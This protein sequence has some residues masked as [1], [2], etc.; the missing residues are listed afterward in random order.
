VPSTFGQGDVV[1]DVPGQAGGQRRMGRLDGVGVEHLVDVKSH[2]GPRH[3]DYQ[4][5][6]PPLR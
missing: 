2:Q 3:V 4:F 6:A 5:S 1:L